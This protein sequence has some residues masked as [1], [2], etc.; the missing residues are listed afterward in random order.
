MK[1]HIE[2]ADIFRRYGPAYREVHKKEMPLRHLRAMN[3][4]EICRTSVLGGHVEECDECGLIKVSY[5]SC[6]NRHCPKCQCLDKERWL[7]SRKR[8][9]LPVQYF[10]VVFTNPEELS[11][12]SLRNQPISYGI[13]FKAAS[14]TLKELSGDPKHLGADIG[15]I[16]ILHTWSQTLIH[17]PHI[18]FIVPG[19]GLSPDGIKWISCNKDFFIHFEVLSRLFR[20]KYLYYLKKAYYSGDLIL[21]GKIEYLKEKTAFER[22]CFDLYSKEWDVYSKPS[23]VTSESVIEYLGRYTHR[24]AI[25]NNRIISLEN[26]NITFQ[27]RDRRD[28]NKI[29]PITLDAFE[30]I[31]RFLYHVLPEGFMKIRH[32]G[33]LSNR[34]RKDK[35]LICKK[36]LGVEIKDSG[37]SGE[38]ESW[39]DL[40]LRITGLDPGICPSC[41]KGKMVLK[42]K[43]LP[44]RERDPP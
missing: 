39:E 10:H 15:F 29:K 31:R 8:D 30:F 38:K 27:Y 20:G 13:H 26:D 28:N 36:L 16:G 32:Y 3:A 34:N 18:H 4:I 11:P 41:K 12:V 44:G 35:L 23:F 37:E 14:E 9:I 43:L 19:G 17:H 2:V 7:E 1:G 6:R 42:K 40:L 24:I 5:N 21:S 33:I 25:T 22:F